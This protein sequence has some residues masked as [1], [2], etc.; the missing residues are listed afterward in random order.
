MSENGRLDRARNEALKRIDR[1]ARN[2]WILLAGAFLTEFVLI[3]GYIQLADFS[4]R[5]HVL[6]FWS[7]LS[8][9]TLIVIG[10]SVLAAYGN[11]QIRLLLKAIETANPRE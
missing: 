9:F 2:F 10:L 8:I 6:I 7:M 1:D 4:D 5:I 11:R 3:W